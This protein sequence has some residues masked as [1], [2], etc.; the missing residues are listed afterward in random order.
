MG[1]SIFNN[2]EI[3]N[4]YVLHIHGNIYK[5]FKICVIV[6]FSFYKSVLSTINFRA[7]LF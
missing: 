7:E 3:A 1:T 2:I 5:V 4:N 6:L